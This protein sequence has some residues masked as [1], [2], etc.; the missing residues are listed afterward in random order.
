[1]LRTRLVVALTALT[2]VV[3][4]LLVGGFAYLNFAGGTVDSVIA[5]DLG[6]TH[7]LKEIADAYAVDI[8]DNVHK[9]RSG[10]RS[11]EE[12]AQALADSLKVIERNWAEFITHVNHADEIIKRD[13]AI[14]RM[15]AAGPAL[16]ELGAILDRRDQQALVAFAEGQLYPA[17]DP[18]SEAI[19]VLVD[20]Q[21]M[22]ANEAS[23]VLK[24]LTG[25]MVIAMIFMLAVSAVG[26]GHAGYIAIAGVSRRLKA[27]TVALT[28]LSEGDTDTDVPYLERKD[29]IGSLARAAEVFR[30]NALK[31]R[32]LGEAEVARIAAAQAERERMMAAL[33]ES[34]GDV[35]SAAV[36][37]DFTRRV[38]ADFADGELNRLAD[39]INQLVDTVDRGLAAAGRVLSAMAEQDLGV[40]MT[41]SWHGAFATLQGDLNRLAGKFA[42]V[43]AT[44]RNM[45]SELRT[46]TGEILAGANDLSERTTRQA[47]TIEETTAA[48]EQFAETAARNAEAARSA[49]KQAEVLAEAA[50]HGKSTMLQ[51][52]AAM[53][54]ITDSAARIASIIGLIDDIAFQTNLLALNASVEAAR[55]GEAGKGFAV[56]AVEVRRLAQSAAN[57]S[58][59]VKQL[60]ATATSEVNAGSVHLNAAAEVLSDVVVG[61]T[62][63][64]AMM[65]D[66]A[67]ASEAQA[68]TVTEVFTAVRQLDEMTQH[69]AALVEQTNAAIEQTEGQVG[70]LDDIVR[71]FVVSAPAPRLEAVQAR[72]A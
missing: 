56:V 62:A 19:G 43:V 8:V 48:M 37:G 17:I 28:R 10:A 52:T 15:T 66:I 53:S 71:R 58:S 49:R 33:G 70:N 67:Q 23:G 11:F 41:G 72:A 38:S 44:L 9:V 2:V 1:M 68:T 27:T 26:I 50:R 29:E 34:F 6:P 57:A 51:S 13:A 60:V 21:L 36:A 16:D 61:V 65:D 54:R 69:N 55:A 3:G 25:T 32:E 45:S 47:A 59:E 18:I 35:V 42:E 31:I 5:D 64:V 20:D 14:T 46:A 4:C 30:T 40:R 39:N 22:D 24:S 7:L 63:N 12:G